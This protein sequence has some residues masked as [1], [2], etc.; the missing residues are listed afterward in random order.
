MPCRKIKYKCKLGII[1]TYKIIKNLKCYKKY[2][3]NIKKK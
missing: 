3:T 1:S 2:V